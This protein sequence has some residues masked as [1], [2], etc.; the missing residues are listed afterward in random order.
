MAIWD[1]LD[2]DDLINRY[3]AG[4][5]LHSAAKR[6][7]V[8]RYV[9]RRVLREH[10]ITLRMKLETI[11]FTYKHRVNADELVTRYLAGESMKGLGRLW[12]R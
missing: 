9:I 1:T 3:L 12:N 11:P 5:S 8:D 4:E 7:G 6:L 2:A 10:N